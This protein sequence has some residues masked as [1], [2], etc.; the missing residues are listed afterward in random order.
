M[1]EYIQ[2]DVTEGIAKIVLDRPDVLNAFH[3]EMIAEL[4]AALIDSQERD[5]VYSIVLTG[6]G[7]GF[8]TGADIS[9][10]G[11]S[12]QQTRQEAGKHLWAIQNV[13]RQLHKGPKPSVAAINGPA[14]GAGC[15]FALACDMRIIEEDAYMREQFVNIG[16]VPGDGGGWLLPRL[17][18]EAKAKEYILTGKNITPE[19]AEDMG[20]VVKVVEPNTAEEAAMELAEELRDKPALAVQRSKLL[21]DVTQSYE[22]YG[23]AAIEA[24]WA[25]KNHPEHTEAI[26]ALR[27]DREPNFDREY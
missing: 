25:A 2:Y 11:D 23:Q 13:V 1:Y 8:C 9:S 12:D 10:M 21:I 15:D 6:A 24:Q 5:D 22:E 27:E 17:V 16:L 26:T 3:E 19:A 7:R 14:L 18:G 4:V 20:L